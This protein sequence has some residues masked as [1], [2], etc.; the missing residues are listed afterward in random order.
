VYSK[1]LQ[2]HGNLEIRKQFSD[3]GITVL[4]NFGIDNNL[5]GKSFLGELK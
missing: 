3:I 1:S 5:Q 4:D 2:E